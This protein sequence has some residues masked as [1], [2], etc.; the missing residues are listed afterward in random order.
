V[1]ELLE[2]GEVEV[3]AGVRDPFD[4]H[5]ERLRNVRGRGWRK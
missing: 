2:G 1:G 5:A 3:L 4:L